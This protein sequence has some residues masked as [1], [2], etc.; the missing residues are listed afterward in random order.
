MRSG[1]LA[2]DETNGCG[3]SL[4]G[5]QSVAFKWVR[6]ALPADCCETLRSAFRSWSYLTQKDTLIWKVKLVLTGGLG[7]GKTRLWWVCNSS[8]V[9]NQSSA[10]G[11][12]PQ[13]SCLT[14]RKAFIE[15]AIFF[16][17]LIFQCDFW[18]AQ[19]CSLWFAAWLRGRSGSGVLC[20]GHSLISGGQ[21]AQWRR[22]LPRGEPKAAWFA[23]LKWCEKTRRLHPP[24]RYF[25]LEAMLLKAKQNI[26][27]NYNVGL[28]GNHILCIMKF[29]IRERKNAK[30]KAMVSLVTPGSV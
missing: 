30:E 29:I 9:F 27:I 18:Q 14:D 26:F 24:I 23:W 3:H 5:Q 11:D 4:L 19:K 16:A 17:A 2:S 10:A 22:C 20:S 6:P 28:K 12:G 1:W 13:R 25:F 15:P 21:R 8:G 7:E